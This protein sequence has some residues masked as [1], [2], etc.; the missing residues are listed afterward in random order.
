MTPTPF[1]PISP[2]EIPDVQRHPMLD[3]TIYGTDAEIV[4]QVL[5]HVETAKPIKLKTDDIQI[6]R[7]KARSA[8]LNASRSLRFLKALMDE[9]LI[10]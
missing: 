6:L 7:G 3:F 8:L 4:F 1:E 9:G 5:Q 10:S 2:S